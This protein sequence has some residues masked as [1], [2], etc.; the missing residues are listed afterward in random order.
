MR[1]HLSREN[2]RWHLSHESVRWHLSRENVR[3][4]SVLAPRVNVSRGLE[5]D[6]CKEENGERNTKEKK[7]ERRSQCARENVRLCAPCAG[8]HMR[9]CAFVPRAL[10][11]ACK[12]APLCPVR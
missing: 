8:V 6:M 10:V 4:I 11:C 12:R 9:T 1:W 2:V 5:R 3:F 7:E